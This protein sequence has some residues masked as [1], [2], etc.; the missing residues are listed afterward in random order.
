MTTSWGSL[1]NFFILC[2]FTSVPGVHDVPAGPVRQDRRGWARTYPRRSHDRQHHYDATNTMLP[3]LGGSV[4]AVEAGAEA[5]GVELD[6]RTM[7]GGQREPA[8]MAAYAE[9]RV[10]ACLIIT[11]E[12]APEA[13]RARFDSDH[14]GSDRWQTL[15]ESGEAHRVRITKLTSTP[16]PRIVAD[17]GAG[18]GPEDADRAGAVWRLP[19]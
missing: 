4:G 16:L 12:S 18:E 13:L 15:E 10:G 1:I 5:N 7:P 8:V 17:T 11:S 9:V 19:V 2:S 3:R 6:L 14:P